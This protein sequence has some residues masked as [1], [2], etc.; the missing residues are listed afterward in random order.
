[1]KTLQYHGCPQ[2]RDAVAAAAGAAIDAA[3]GCS[4]GGAAG[5]GSR[6]QQL[7]G[8]S[9]EVVQPAAFAAVA[10]HFG[11]CAAL[12]ARLLDWLCAPQP[13]GE[14]PFGRIKHVSPHCAVQNALDGPIGWCLAP[15]HSCSA[16]QA[17]SLEPGKQ[18]PFQGTCAAA[19]MRA[20]PP[21]SDTVRRC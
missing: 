12:H 8:A 1:M 7:A 21:A 17:A 2:V 15:S 5:N 10:R 18:D 11:H 9:S 16:G 13:T 14:E 20:A 6:P 19:A 3:A 4:T